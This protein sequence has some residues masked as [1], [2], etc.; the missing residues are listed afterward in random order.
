[1]STPNEK[2]R[3]AYDSMESSDAATDDALIQDELDTVAG[4]I[5]AASPDAAAAGAERMGPNPPDKRSD[6]TE[7]AAGSE[8]AY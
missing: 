2:E 7:R 8:K 5:R 6:P 4:G 3:K 1:M